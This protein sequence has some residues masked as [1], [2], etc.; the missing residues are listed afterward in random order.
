[1]S[2][3]SRIR[4]RNIT[5]RRVLHTN[6]IK[7][8]K[9]VR[10]ADEAE[11][12]VELKFTEANN[13]EDDENKKK[14]AP[15]NTA[16]R[17]SP[18]TMLSSSRVLRGRKEEL[19][20]LS[21]SACSSNCSSKTFRGRSASTEG[22]R[23]VKKDGRRRQ[24]SLPRPDGIAVRSPQIFQGKIRCPWITPNSGMIPIL[25]PIQTIND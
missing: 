13:N 15:P 14:M 11:A 9:P 1:M 22:M 12:A 17:F 25:H 3:A 16:S 6:K 4:T 7:H 24:Q 8:S 5:D 18:P 10:K 20:G 21:L 23:S 19:M 2:G